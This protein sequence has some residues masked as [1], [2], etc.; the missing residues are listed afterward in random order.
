MSCGTAELQRLGD[1]PSVH[2]VRA[3]HVGDGSR[4]AADAIVATGAETNPSD[5]SR[6]QALSLAIH[7]AG[8]RGLRMRK[9]RV[10]R[11]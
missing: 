3:F 2:V 8:A 10:H 4:D 5:G 11:W 6:E 1:M 7:A 9:R